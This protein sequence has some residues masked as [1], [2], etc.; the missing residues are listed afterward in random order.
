MMRTGGGGGGDTKASG[1][2]AVSSKECRGAAS[3]MTISV[4]TTSDRRKRLRVL[5]TPRDP[6]CAWAVKGR[7]EHGDPR[8]H[9]PDRYNSRRRERTWTLR[10]PSEAALRFSL[11]SARTVEGASAYSALKANFQAKRV[12]SDPRSGTCGRVRKDFP[13]GSFS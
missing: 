5:P 12:S 3:A 13:P 7:P 11:E 10:S 8:R 1:R 9:L 2:F 6:S 4:A